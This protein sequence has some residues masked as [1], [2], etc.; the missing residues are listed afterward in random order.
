MHFVIRRLLHEASTPVVNETNVTLNSPNNAD[1]GLKV[2]IFDGVSNF[3]S[4]IF[5]H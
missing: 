4:D 3:F 1:N 5:K 2:T